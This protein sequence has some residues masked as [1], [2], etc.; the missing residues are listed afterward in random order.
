MFPVH[1]SEISIRYTPMSENKEINK[2][3][4]SKY[5]GVTFQPM[6]VKPKD[7]TQLDPFPLSRTYSGETGRDTLRIVYSNNGLFWKKAKINYPVENIRDPSIKKIGH[8]YYII[9]THGI[10]KTDDFKNWD[11]LSWKYSKRFSNEWAPEFVK[12]KN[13]KYYVIMAAS[14]K[15]S[16]KFHLYYSSFNKQN[17]EIKNNWKLIEGNDF[18]NNMIDGHIDFKNGHYYLW[19]KDENTKTLN[20]AT[21][22]YF[23][24][25]YKIM[26]NNI[27]KS[28]D[29]V[30]GPETLWINS[31]RIILYFDTYDL[32]EAKFHGIHYTESS[33]GGK[34][35]TNVKK[36]RSDF[37]VR[38][39]E[40]IQNK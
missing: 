26:N 17:G 30:E 38:H 7:G 19:Y 40:P 6:T 35:W 5:L 33:D 21:S 37:I 36:I 14:Q 32:P 13:N 2:I 1:T 12:T 31:N 27:P 34:H 18:P 4:N 24:K 15:G 9:Y 10:L 23:N 8:N 39:F 28:F 11:I 29:G 25:G 16:N 20:V 3:K 22:I